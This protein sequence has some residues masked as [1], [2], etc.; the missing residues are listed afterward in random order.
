ME[1]DGGARVSLRSR[2]SRSATLAAAVTTSSNWQTLT[3]FTP[4][5]V[6][7]N[8][9]GTNP[10]A[11]RPYKGY[12]TI[13]EAQNTGGAF[14]HAMQANLKRRLTQGLSLW[15][16]LHLVQEPRLRILERHEHH[17]R[18]RQQHHVRTQRLRH[19]PRACGELR[20]EYS[21]R[22]PLHAT[23]SCARRWATGSSP[24]PSRLSPAVRLQELSRGTSTRPASDLVRAISTTCTHAHRLCRTS[25]ARRHG[26][27]V[28]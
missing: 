18:I 5:T 25:L 10:D 8:P 23:G 21:L 13:I 9:K 24:E 19:A 7:A 3:S 16:R 22:N 6:Q 27:T 14:Y 12:S 28:V 15:R 1:H 20:L 17:Q 2:S 26:A 4:G 11:L